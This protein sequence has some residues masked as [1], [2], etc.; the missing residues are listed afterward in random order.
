MDTT[1]AETPDPNE[2]LFEDE[3]DD[4]LYANMDFDKLQQQA[5]KRQ[6]ISHE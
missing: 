3:D 4:Q 1:P 5:A 6:R 2:A